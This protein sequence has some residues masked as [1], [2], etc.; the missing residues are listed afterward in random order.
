MPPT[1]NGVTTTDSE[2][3]SELSL[4]TMVVHQCL[5]TKAADATSAHAEVGVRVM[6]TTRSE[7]ATV[8]WISQNLV[9]LN[10]GQLGL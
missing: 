1:F 10:F 8:F 9:L 6:T 5:T 4:V 7:V 3:F 2:L